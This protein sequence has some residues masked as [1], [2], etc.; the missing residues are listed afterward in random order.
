ML[1][2][3]VLVLLAFMTLPTVVVVAVS[4]NPTAILSFPPSGLSMRWYVNAIIA[5]AGPMARPVVELAGCTR[6]YGG[7]R[8]VAGST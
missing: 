4:F 3:A 7:V 2:L 1:R 5:E 8:A 6:D